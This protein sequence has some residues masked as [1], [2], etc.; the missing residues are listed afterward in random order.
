MVIYVFLL[1]EQLGCKMQ[2]RLFELSLD[3]LMLHLGKLKRGLA[4]LELLTK[5]RLDQCFLA[6]L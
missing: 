6:D 1:F 4:L 2:F 3:G 5:L